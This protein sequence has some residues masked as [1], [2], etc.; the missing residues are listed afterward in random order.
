MQHYSHILAICY[1]EKDDDELNKCSLSN[2]HVY[3]KRKGKSYSFE[4]DQVNALLFKQKRLLFPLVVGGITGSLFLIAGFNFL[5][6][7]WVA[8]IVGMAGMLLFYY[9][10]IGSKTI[11]IATK[12]KEYDIFIN[13]PT[14]Q[15]EGFVAMV[16]E[17]FTLGKSKNITYYLPLSEEAWQAN[18]TNGFI[19]TPD[20][21]L[22]LETEPHIIDGKAIVI[23]PEEVSNAINY[24]LDEAS[25]KV[26]PYIFGRIE[27]SHL[28]L[29][30]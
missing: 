1:I 5:I 9:G 14:P 21:G 4:L 8:M 12:L 3:I 16:N 30:N 10:W 24:Q 23:S 11:T 2:E 18:L 27:T 25:N 17:Y 19:D 15:L 13:E 28:A 7:I 22:K 29:A 26:V 20:S 6:N